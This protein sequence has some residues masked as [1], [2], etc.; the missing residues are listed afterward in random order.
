MPNPLPL[1]LIHNS[2]ISEIIFLQTSFRID[3]YIIFIAL[4][5]SF[6]FFG[7]NIFKISF[8]IDHINFIADK[9]G[10]LGGHIG[11]NSPSILVPLVHVGI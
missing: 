10:E 2:H 3:S 6:I 1:W 4:S 5:S 8:M 7:G 11:I 9:S